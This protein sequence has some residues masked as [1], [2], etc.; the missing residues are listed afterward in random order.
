MPRKKKLSPL[1]A[2]D[3]EM[4]FQAGQNPAMILDADSRILHSNRATQQIIGLTEEALR[5]R[6]CYEIFHHSATPPAGCP[7]QKL[8][9]SAQ[10]EMADMEVQ[11]LNRWFRVSCSLLPAA[12]GEAPS[13]LHVATDI[14][15]RIE[16]EKAAKH[17]NRLYF[18]LSQVNQTIVRTQNSAQLFENICQVAVDFGEFRLAWVGL[19]DA[20]NNALKPVAWRGFDEGYLSNIQISTDP[21]NPAS[22]GP[23]GQAIL[24]GQVVC[25]SN[26]GQDAKM[27]PWREQ[28]L[29]R[30]YES[31]AAVPLREGGKIIGALALYASE[32]GF[33]GEREQN[34]LQEIGGDIS[35][36]L[37]SFVSLREKAQSEAALRESEERFRKAFLISP[38]SININRL[39]D[40][41]YISINN[42]FTQIMGYTAQEIVGKTSLEM[43]IW[44]NPDDR[45]KLVEGLRRNGEVANLQAQ[46]RAKD[47]SLRIGLMSASV[48]EL[49]GEPHIIS[50]TRD[51]TLRQNAEE[52]LRRSEILLAEAQ[53][54]G[55]LGHVEWVNSSDELIC[56]QEFLQI[57]ELPPQKRVSRQVLREYIHPDD[58]ER[59]K[60]ADQQ[61][62][63]NRANIEYDYRLLLPGG[64]VRWVRQQSKIDY[65]ENGHPT[66]MIGVFQD[67]S[68]RK[69]A[70]EQLAESEASYRGLF[71]GIG[72]AIYVQDRQGTFLDINAAAEK[73]YG[74]PRETL[75]GKNPAFVGAPGKNDL[76]KVGRLFQRA[77]A[78]EPQ[79][80]EFWGQR[81]NGEIFPKEVRLAR[82]SY[83]G[84]EV[85]IASADDISAR[86]QAEL[87]LRQRADELEML[88]QSGL[89]LNHLLTPREI[90]QKIV[91]LVREKLGWQHITVR[92]YQPQTQ[93][94][95]II[96][97]HQPGLKDAEARQ[98]AENLFQSLV[99]KPG[100]GLSGWAFEHHQNVRG[101]DVSHDPRFA[102]T[103]AGL[104]SGLY[105]PLMVGER[106]IGV[107]SVESET[108]NA[109]SEADERL[110]FTL[111]AQ[112]ASALENARLFDETRQRVAE[113][114]TVNRVSAVTRSAQRQEQLL[115]ATLT[116]ILKALDLKDGSVSLLDEASGKLIQSQAQGWPAEIHETPQRPDEGIFGRVFT[117]GSA[118]ITREF[119]N[120]PLARPEAASKF[121]PGW[122]GVCVP[123]RSPDK[124]FGVLL[125]AA[126]S[127][128][129]FTTNDLRLLNTIADMT[130]NALHRI[131]LSEETARRMQNL[132]ALR[133]I[134]RA[135]TSSFDMQ[136]GLQTI[137]LHARTQLG[138]DAAD[139]LLFEPALQL[140]EY[141]AGQ[142]FY[143]NAI[144]RT[145]VRLGEGHAGRAAL[146][147]C[148]IHIA[149][150][151]DAAANFTRAALLGGEHF[152]SYHA[153]PLISKGEIRGV[154]EVF[155]RS[156]SLPGP[157]WLNFL[158]TLA[159]QTA[160][161]IDNAQ[162]FENLKRSNLE[163]SMAYDAT[164][165][166]WSRALELRDKE[167]EGHTL[168]V[169]GL[170]LRLA[171]FCGVTGADLLHLRRGALLH[172]IGK[173]GIPDEILLKAGAL[174]KDE[175]AIIQNHVQLA[176]DMLF[177]I[178]YLRPALDVPF[179]HHEKWDGSGYPR[180]LKGEEIP[181]AA[182]IFAIVDVFDA[183]T[184]ARPYRP[185]WS[186]AATLEY[187]RKNRGSHFDP[188]ILENFFKMLEEE[189]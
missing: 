6:A 46:F 127:E 42:G 97:F 158:E 32:P 39:R 153:A 22:Q 189:G 165:E 96:A 28:A 37:D 9:K 149:D 117:S 145:R 134:D 61:A 151:N 116:E 84:Q 120:D 83:F 167:T 162:L 71:D 93:A 119:I 54:V 81:A 105:V 109:F 21:A 129:S 108:P 23:I 57:F 55:K 102:P 65:D 137:L 110:L 7:L 68:E 144:E 182:R 16:A 106:A 20:E 91:A 18:T 139:V 186:R 118:H 107:I 130:G 25:S 187:L 131:H 82:G 43:N 74:Y 159:G 47:G 15:E 12:P 128:H 44:A 114:E 34:L 45:R 56:S 11:A 113:L 166:G 146:E 138:V 52:R 170:A 141:K 40:G 69:Q 163:L 1:P 86:K 75:I 24:S 140:L 155:Q 152:V 63:A 121:P 19:I 124:I 62:F 177:P 176:Y 160:L 8:L 100:Q 67:I 181:L 148:L 79:R 133:E 103:F 73:M 169:T 85:V 60:Q 94:L 171:K 59:L 76:A 77:L 142:G 48:V 35:F 135:I 29:R 3:W 4:V 66:R 122:G 78:G 95:E 185:A 154:L 33:F 41:L 184:S 58:L 157:D 143:T 26:I 90:G 99:N 17:A 31:L 80:F 168:R 179:C 112:A 88:H 161:A 50:T 178:E 104:N 27:R 111:S 38:D 72:E 89:T 53:A 98:A 172:D 132:Q 174:T 10:S 123:L 126:P 156:R 183:L 70:E 30:G 136:P 115:A 64:K 188:Q 180:G 147:R 13:F 87:S 36:A 51:I 2:P 14:T 92:L 101:G 49:A 150:L 175:R 173:I 5:G 125:A 164:I